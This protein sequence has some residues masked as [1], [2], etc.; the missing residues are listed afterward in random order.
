MEA[1]R[2]SPHLLPYLRQS[3]LFFIVFSILFDLWTWDILLSLPL[4]IP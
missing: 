2:I 3:L 1:L 4:N